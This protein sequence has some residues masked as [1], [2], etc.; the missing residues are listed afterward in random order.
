MSRGSHHEKDH[1]LLSVELDVTDVGVTDVVVIGAGQAGLS[2]SYFL[3]RRGVD[4]VVLDAN[5]APGGAWLHRWPSLRMR[6]VHGI[7]ELPGMPFEQPAPDERA[8]EAIPSYF[9]RYEALH[10]LPVVRPVN[11]TRVRD[12]GPLL[13]VEISAGVWT[14]RGLINAT[15]T[16]RRPFW[17]HYPGQETFQGRQLHTADYQGPEAFAGKRVVV[18][19]GGASAT[20]L[21]MELAPFA[22][23]TRWVTRHEPVWREGPFTE[24]YGRWVVGLVEERVRAGLIPRSVVSV[25]GLALTE[26]TRAA[27][28]SG[29]LRRRP[30]FS[31]I[32]PSGVEWDSGA[33]G[34]GEPERFDADV[35][36]WATGFRHDLDHLAPLRLRGPGGGIQVDGTRV[37]ADPRIHLVGYGPSASTIG[38]NRAGRSA[39]RELVGYLEI[40]S[41]AAAG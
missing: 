12:D 17:P 25:T 37:V 15:G 22:A 33:S 35:I 30:I 31:R 32:T 21:L 39:V 6:T 18:V 23:E 34:T 1:Y 13:K 10:D 19:G 5:D 20:Q 14:A 41:L 29:V 8:N 38:A 24:D 3:R 11:V 4:H 36:L 16:W 40:G 26:E 2:A 9:A 28:E 7:H 27:I